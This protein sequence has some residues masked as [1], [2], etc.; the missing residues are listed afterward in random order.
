VVEK[1]VLIK[2]VCCL[3]DWLVLAGIVR[4]AMDSRHYD[5]IYA[6]EQGRFIIK[7]KNTP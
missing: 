3:F 5:V 6:K 4:F 2:L 7:L 1:H